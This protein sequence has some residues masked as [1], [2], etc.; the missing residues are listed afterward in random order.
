MKKDVS[1]A[2]ALARLEEIVEK[3]ESQDVDLE[4]Q[5]ELLTEGVTLH[6]ICQDKLKNAQ[7]KIDKLL[8]SEE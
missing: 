3:L 6:K 4:E 7:T 8:K 5:V 2:K 1:F